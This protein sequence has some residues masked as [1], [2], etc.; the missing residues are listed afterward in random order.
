MCFQQEI[1]FSFFIQDLET[2]KSVVLTGDL[3]C[4]HQEID[5]YNP[6]VKL[7]LFDNFCT[8]SLW[9]YFT[10]FFPLSPSECYFKLFLYQYCV[11][12]HI[13]YIVFLHFLLCLCREIGEAQDLQMRK[14]HRSN[15]ISLNE[16]WLIP[17]GDNTNM[18]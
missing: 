3:N 13:Y 11:D 6:D 5:I 1:T 16:D 17:S 15:G 8:I 18:W 10:T 4:A 2:R 9:I 7:S 14:E 12:T